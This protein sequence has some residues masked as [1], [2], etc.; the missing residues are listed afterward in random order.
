M[1]GCT[2]DAAVRASC[3]SSAL[4]MTTAE[5]SVAVLTRPRRALAWGSVRGGARVGRASPSS[6]AKAAPPQ[7]SPPVIY[8]VMSEYLVT[9]FF[10][11]AATHAAYSCRTLSRTA[12]IAPHAVWCESRA[13]HLSARA[14][15]SVVLK[16]QRTTYLVGIRGFGVRG[17]VG[18]RAKRG[19]D[20]AGHRVPEPSRA[21]RIQSR[22]CGS[23]RVVGAASSRAR[24]CTQRR[25]AGPGRCPLDPFQ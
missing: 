23:R 19:V 20:A 15:P 4:D 14:K 13:R 25:R 1:L 2:L 10:F 18:A 8:H 11:S 7:S 21:P 6:Q 24:R 3:A 12:S 5:K 16:R 9:F 17:R 22:Q